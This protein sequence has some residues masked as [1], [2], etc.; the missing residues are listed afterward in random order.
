MTPLNGLMQNSPNDST[1]SEHVARFNR[2]ERLVVAA[3]AL[4]VMLGVVATVGRAAVLC[5]YTRADCPEL[6]RSAVW[7]A[8]DAIQ[9][10]TGYAVVVYTRPE[11]SIQMVKED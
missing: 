3:L 8:A 7:N 4:F 10:V 1:E 2:L 6:T 9:N 5:T 11:I